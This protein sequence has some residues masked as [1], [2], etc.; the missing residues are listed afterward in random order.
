MRAVQP[1]KVSQ[2]VFV[3]NLLHKYFN[4]VTGRV[5][6]KSL[7]LPLSEA[8]Q[9][10]DDIDAFDFERDSENALQVPLKEEPREMEG[11]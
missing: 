2:I 5:T 9:G 7:F 10:G 4:D 3:I 6:S 1:K 8:Q 11:K